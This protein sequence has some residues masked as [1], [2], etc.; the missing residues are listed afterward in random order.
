MDGRLFTEILVCFFFLSFFL[1]PNGCYITVKYSGLS[2]W[3]THICATIHFI[4]QNLHTFY[5]YRTEPS[6]AGWRER[7]R[8]R[9]VFLFL[10]FHT[11]NYFRESVKNFRLTLGSFHV[12]LAIVNVNFFQWDFSEFPIQLR[13]HQFN[14]FL[15]S[16]INQ[17]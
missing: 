13:D 2:K 9:G 3:K 5:S 6:C 16:F 17:I 8:K 4:F 7:E 1:S 15:F 11:I 14:D 12:W 10:S